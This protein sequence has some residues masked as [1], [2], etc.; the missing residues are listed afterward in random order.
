MSESVRPRHYLTVEE[1][2]ALEETAAIKHEYI[3]GRVFAMVGTTK[4]HNRIV[5]N[6][7]RKLDDAAGGTPC[8]VFFEAVKL[9]VS[10]DVFYY[11]DIMV[12][13]EP[14]EDPLIE[15]RPCLVVEV[16]SPKTE[17][18]DRRE[19]LLA[20][21]NL[22]SLRAYLVVAQDRRW[23]EHHFRDESGDWRNNIVEEGNVPLD[24]PPD[25]LL[26][27]EDIYRGMDFTQ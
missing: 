13:C 5:G 27:F 25:T 17:A 14:D 20:Y 19:K 23:V 4:R 6:I 26:A 7:Y 2:L 24:C 10:G 3:G 11:P 12:A 9:R 8:R 21:R 1:Y 16:V 18:T 22:P 15:H